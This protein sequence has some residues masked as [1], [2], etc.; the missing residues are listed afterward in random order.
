MKFGLKSKG[1]QDLMA[2]M[3]QVGLDPMI[4]RCRFLKYVPT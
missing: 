3:P 1:F 2:I 4:I